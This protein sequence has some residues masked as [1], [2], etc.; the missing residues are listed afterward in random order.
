MRLKLEFPDALLALAVAAKTL[1]SAERS[2][3]ASM[4]T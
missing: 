2:S 1:P 4:W 3:Q